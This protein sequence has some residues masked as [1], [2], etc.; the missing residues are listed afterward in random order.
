[1]ALGQI[2]H[3]SFY[4]EDLEA[5]CKFFVE[6]LG[7]KFV[8]RGHGGRTIDLVS[9]EGGPTFEFG[10]ITEEYKNARIESNLPH[11]AAR[12]R[13]YLDHIAFEVSGLDEKVQELKGKDVKFFSGPVLNKENNRL[14]ADLYDPEGHAWIQLQDEK[15]G[16]EEKKNR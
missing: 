7:F 6:T 2:N 8:R 9:S 16:S 4:V 10:Q 12:R 15:P 5:T 14:L 1:M 11:I 13:P 3:L